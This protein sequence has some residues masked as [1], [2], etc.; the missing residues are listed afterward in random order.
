MQPVSVT[1]RAPSTLLPAMLVMDSV[2][3]GQT[4]WASSVILVRAT[5]GDLAHRVAAD[6]VVAAVKDQL[7]HSVIRYVSDIAKAHTLSVNL[8]I[9]MH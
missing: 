8:S 2:S 3:A 6:R 7:P 5:T 4:S 9:E 1:L